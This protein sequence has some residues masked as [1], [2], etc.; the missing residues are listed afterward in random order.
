MEESSAFLFDSLKGA[1]K[2]TSLESVKLKQMFGPFPASLATK[3]F[4][5]V[6]QLS[7]ILSKNSVENS[8]SVESNQKYFGHNIKLDFD[9]LDLNF[10][11]LYEKCEKDSKIVASADSFVQQFQDKLILH[12]NVDLQ[13]S[14]CQNNLSASWLEQ[15]CESYVKTN[16]GSICSTDLASAIF[17]ILVS[18]KSNDE[19][20]NELFDLVGFDAFDLILSLLEKRQEIINVGLE[21]KKEVGIGIDRAEFQYIDP[22][23]KLRKPLVGSQVTIQ[24]T[25]FFIFSMIN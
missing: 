24:V 16:P 13:K 2:I 6:L 12:Q 25:C 18:P 23:R 5:C 22:T 20:Q 3:A 1:K 9:Y 17:E 10:E 21:K 19:I 7:N 14:T 4:D 8:N 11:E 15:Q